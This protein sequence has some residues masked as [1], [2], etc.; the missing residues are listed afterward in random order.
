MEGYRIF[1]KDMQRRQ[2]GGVV[3]YVNYQLEGVELCLGMD[4]ELTERLWVS[5][6]GRAGTGGITVR[7]CYRPADQGY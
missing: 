1:R 4:E 3:L 2:G 5:I 6:E 7:A